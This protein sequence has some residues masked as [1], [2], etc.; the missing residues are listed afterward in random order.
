MKKLHNVNIV[1]IDL[2]LLKKQANDLAGMDLSKLDKKTSDSL[3][4]LLEFI[5]HVTDVIEGYDK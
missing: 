1:G 5:D 4:G 3:E 2:E